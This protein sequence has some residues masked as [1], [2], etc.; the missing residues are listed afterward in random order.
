ME[1]STI[2]Q[3]LARFAAESLASSI[4]QGFLLAAAVWL[5]LR[6]APKVSANHRFL[7]WTIVF[8]AAAFLPLLSLSYSA[9]HAHSRALP[10]ARPL[11]HLR[12][13]WAI[14]IAALWLTMSFYR[15]CTLLRNALKLRD[16]WSRAVPIHDER[17]SLFHS[18]AAGLRRAQICSC[19]DLDQPCVIGF[20]S[21]RILIPDWLL[22]KLTEVEAG[23]IVLHE[24]EHLR[25]FDDW[26]NLL[27]K[28]SLV[29]FPLNP[30]LLWI[31]RRLCLERELACDE[32]VVR[33]TKSAASYATCLTSL[34]EK[35]LSRRAVSLTLAAWDKQSSLA[36][37]V[38]L[39]LGFDRA[40]DPR[41]G[42]ALLAT[43]A[44]GTFAA[45][46]FLSGSPQLV[47]FRALEIDATAPMV[48]QH[49][50]PS[51][52]MYREAVFH[53]DATR[54]QSHELTPHVL[55]N[56]ASVPHSK[57]VKKA[58]IRAVVR[59]PRKQRIEAL[60][61][62]LVVTRW[63]N[64]YSEGETYTLINFDPR[65]SHNLDPRLR[66]SDSGYAVFAP[67]PDH[68]GWIVIQL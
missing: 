40:L 66:E 22:D 33:S 56:T 43:L 59:Q 61:G 35:K 24:T 49:S 11:L 67:A 18:I 5:C 27:Q 7:V 53:P 29:L 23:Q 9:T 20:F 65:M 13:E 1:M 39:I 63:S 41:R 31:E 28:V 30:V 57:I 68:A 45:V 34:A 16:L 15:A 37:R 36:R 50:I 4:W 17:L 60:Q 6:L 26:F 8:L 21:P 47:S 62:W 46:V 32:S 14:A 19:S 51:H 54:A 48:A 38:H 25:R 12:V 44:L 52:A 10:F 42:R 3:I 58:K 2:F 55:T 64:A